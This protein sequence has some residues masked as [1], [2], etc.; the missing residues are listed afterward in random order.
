M[1]PLSVVC[2][3][4]RRVLCL[5]HDPGLEY[6]LAHVHALYLFPDAVGSCPVV[7][8]E[9]EQEQLLDGHFV[10]TGNP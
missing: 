4:E 3:C 6:G 9:S 8:L 7:C 1:P 5:S 2:R 10:V